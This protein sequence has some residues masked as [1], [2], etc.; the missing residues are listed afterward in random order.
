MNFKAALFIASS[1]FLGTTNLYSQATAG[2]TATTVT[3]AKGNTA[4]AAT[5]PAVPMSSEDSIDLEFNARRALL[6]KAYSYGRRFDTQSQKREEKED[7]TFLTH[8]QLNKNQSPVDS[9]VIR[10]SGSF[11]SQVRTVDVFDKT[12]TLLGTWRVGEKKNG[13]LGTV[14]FTDPSGKVAPD[15]GTLVAPA[16]NTSGN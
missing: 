15:H 4:S 11:P 8:I 5:I 9:I 6:D 1:L 14:V 12:D 10:E 3:A 16:N 2:K 13:A 7:G